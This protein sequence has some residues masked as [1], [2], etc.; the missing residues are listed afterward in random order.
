MVKE[1]CFLP[2]K[3]RKA[4]EI[5]DFCVRVQNCCPIMAPRTGLEPVTSLILQVGS[6]ACLLVKFALRGS[7][8]SFASQTAKR[9]SH[10][11]LRGFCLL[12]DIADSNRV[13]GP[14]QKP[15][16]LGGFCFGSPNRARTCDFM[17]NSHALYRLSYRGI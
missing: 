11:A 12:H 4:P 3:T 16:A 13:K 10:R 9:C 8:H 14:K 2:L 5:K 17:I 7:C 6:H 1:G 15:P